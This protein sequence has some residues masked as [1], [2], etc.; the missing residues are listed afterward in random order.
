M[1]KS[2]YYEPWKKKM[3]L[4][5]S[6]EDGSTDYK[7]FDHEIEYFIKD[8]SGKSPIT[9]IEGI[10]V[11]RKVTSSKDNLKT[12]KEAGE[13]L[14]ESDLS[15][16]VKFLHK[17]YGDQE[18]K[19][20]M[21]NY[22]IFNV[23]IETE[24]PETETINLIGIEDINTGE[25]FQLGLKP[26]TGDNKDTKYV[27]CD[28]EAILLERFCKFLKLKQAN[29]LVGWNNSKF[30]VPKIQDRIDALKLKCSMSPLGKV[31]RQYN[32]EIVIPGIEILDCM[33]MYKKF[34]MK[35][36]P[37]F[38]LNYIGMLE[39]K[40]GKLEYEGTINDFWKADWNRFVDYNYQDL[41]VVSKID[42]KKEFISLA[43]NLCT[44]TRTP[45]SKVTGTI[46]VIE[47]YIL[48]HQKKNNLVMTDIQHD[49]AYEETRKI[50]GGHV[51]SSP[52]FYINAMSIDA[53]ALY[54]HNMMMFNIS[55]ETKI[56]SPKEED[57]PNL[58]KSPV[59]GVYYKK[60]TPGILPVIVKK[61]FDDRKA[62]KKKM[63]EAKKAKDYVLAEFY[64]TQQAII[65]V[66][67][68][69][70]YGCCLE[71]HFHLYDYDNGSVITA[72]GREAI[73]HVRECFD[74]YIKEDFHK[75]AKD[76]YPNSTF[77]K[78]S[79][80]KESLSIL[81]DTDSRFLDLDILY[82]TLAPEMKFLD[83]ALDFQKRILEPF[84]TKIMD[85]YAERYNTK[86]MIHFKREKIIAKIYVQA[87]K[88]YAT[89]N[90][91]NEDEIYDTP[92]FAVTGIETKKA[93]LCKYS[94]K[95]LEELLH[96]LFSGEIEEYPNKKKML[97]HIRDANKEF[98]KQSINDLAAAKGI[99]DYDKYAEGIYGFTN[100][101]K[102]TPIYNRCAII[103]NY[104]VDDLKLPLQKITNGTKLKY[105][106]VHENNKYKTNAIGFIGN[107][108]KEFDEI[109]K[110][111]YDMQFEKQYLNISQR[112]F[113]AIGFGLITMKDSKLSK[114]MEE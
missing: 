45:F 110:I 12:L 17:R 52:G 89:L 73:V 100:F 46:A 5:E 69:G 47:G 39:I 18:F 88:K 64:N 56:L 26:Y 49:I 109:F 101:Q 98:R 4:W 60:G 16:E 87:K 107:W 50:K 62:L 68:N 41:Q 28:S 48:R 55:P 21:K 3:H 63:F 43:I 71:T 78:N 14:Y 19:V 66:L 82:K 114:L 36:Q 103:Y 1:F 108:P 85:E 72:V 59:K 92:D 58:I 22:N 10:P 99:S 7:V 74:K 9:S 84:L 11:I 25:I 40:E 44:F 67:A 20:E 53:T 6:G 27:F 38:S 111:D 86:N 102:G 33:E 32:G 31:V 106:Y 29:V 94:R 35:S 23:D 65:K 8:P 96:L 34:T 79:I 95:N 51:E 112:M 93:D 80:K 54:P 81:A 113:D 42:K 83:F 70:V 61:L 105:V 2:V 30:D 91:A 76:Y 57:I 75:V 97:K 13:I 77:T 104:V 15:E 90:L 37:S 24:Y